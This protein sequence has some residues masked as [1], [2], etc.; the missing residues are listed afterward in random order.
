M[1]R[2]RVG[3]VVDPVHVLGRERNRRRVEP[4]VA[5]AVRLTQ[6][7][8]IAGVGFEVEHARGVGVKRRI[9]FHLIVIGETDHGARAHFLAGGEALGLGN[10]ADWRGPLSV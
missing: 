10:D 9:V 1:R 6:G 8:R 3:Q 4:D 7:A 5:L 2:A